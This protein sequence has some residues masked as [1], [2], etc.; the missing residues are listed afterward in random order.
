[1]LDTLIKDALIVDG[2]GAPPRRGSIG[3]RDGRIVDVSDTAGGGGAAARE[4]M[5]A[6]DLALMPGIIDAHTHYDAQLG[7]RTPTRRPPSA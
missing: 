4:V 3:I 5:D 7:T 2:S 1:M 6:G